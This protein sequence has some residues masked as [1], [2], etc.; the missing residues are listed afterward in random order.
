LRAI[1]R[2]GPRDQRALADE[3]L[4]ADGRYALSNGDEGRVEPTA[5]RA[6]LVVQPADRAVPEAVLSRIGQVDICGSGKCVVHWLDERRFLLIGKRDQ[7]SDPQVVLFSLDDN[8]ESWS[9]DFIGSGDPDVPG[10]VAEASIT[11]RP[12]TR[13]QLLINGKPASQ[14]FE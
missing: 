9:T 2:S 12:V 1:A 3:A 4:K 6:S 8:G 5:V 13:Q 11:V 7:G 14:V 10:D